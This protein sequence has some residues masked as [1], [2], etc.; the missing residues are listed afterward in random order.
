MVRTKS[1]LGAGAGLAMILTLASLG[2]CATNKYVDTKTAALSD[3]LHKVEERQAA[4]EAAAKASHDALD[5]RVTDNTQ[6]IAALTDQVSITNK[7][8]SCSANRTA[9]FTDNSVTFAFNKSDLSPEAEKRLT[10]FA[11]KLKADQHAFL[12]IRGHTDARG[13]KAYNQVLGQKRV[14]AA[15]RFLSDQGVAL[16]QLGGLSFGADKP[17]A[18]N[19]KAAGRAQ[20]RRID[21]VFWN[22]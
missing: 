7:L 19:D 5:M 16:N 9:K 11:E 12:E 8:A 10:E 13:G 1:A 6:K 17:A 4:Q 2:A 14:D 22:C 18:P 3:E 21:L 15:L 20:N